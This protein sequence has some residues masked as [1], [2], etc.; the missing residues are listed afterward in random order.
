MCKNE[1]SAA[2]FCAVCAFWY[3]NK[4]SQELQTL[5]ALNRFKQLITTRTRWRIKILE[6]E[7]IHTHSHART[8]THRE[9]VQ[10]KSCRLRNAA[11]SLD[12]LAPINNRKEAIKG[13]RWMDLSCC[14]RSC[15]WRLTGLERPLLFKALQEQTAVRW[16]EGYRL[17]Q[18]TT[19]LTNPAIMREQRLF[20]Y[21]LKG[22]KTG[23]SELNY[24][25]VRDKIAQFSGLVQIFIGV[26]GSLH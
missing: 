14:N 4:S 15:R 26:S 5:T 22:K 18:V 17:R 20:F 3:R 12:R 13:I 1:A 2:Y 8:Q 9:N 16:V 7:L 24:K 6:F 10:Y 23:S 11:L 21:E 19:N 25:R